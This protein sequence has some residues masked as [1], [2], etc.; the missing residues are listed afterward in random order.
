[1][2]EELDSKVK[3]RSRNRRGEQNLITAIDTHDEF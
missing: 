3:L 2:E 1:M